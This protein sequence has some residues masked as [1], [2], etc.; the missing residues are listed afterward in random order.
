MRFK[1]LSLVSASLLCVPFSVWAEAPPP[2]GSKPLTEIL[3]PI[4]T[5]PDFAYFEEVEF[6]NGK[7]NIEYYK[8]DGSKHKM[9]IDPLTGTP[10][11]SA[12]AR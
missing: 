12:P 6:E 3:R 1:L 5:G 10:R 11:E 8:K 9:E 2:E 7:Y 4:E